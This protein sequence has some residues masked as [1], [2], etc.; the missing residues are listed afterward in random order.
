MRES[1]LDPAPARTAIVFASALGEPA[2]HARVLGLSRGRAAD[3]S[4]AL[5]VAFLLAVRFD[6]LRVAIRKGGDFDALTAHA[7]GAP[8]PASIEG[9]WPAPRDE[10][11]ARFLAEL[12][13][14]DRIDTLRE[15]EG[16]D[17][18]RNPRAFATL[19]D[20]AR[21]PAPLAED[22]AARLARRFEEVV[23]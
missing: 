1:P 23:A 7:L 15:R 21:A 20:L 6:A 3:Q 5:R 8:L 16:D 14:L 18:F 19:R 2:L 17:W 9:A 12:T 11:L 22:A 13:V 4:R 10:D